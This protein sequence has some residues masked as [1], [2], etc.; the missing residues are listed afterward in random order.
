ME[1][2]VPS[3]SGDHSQTK[4]SKAADFHKKN[5]SVSS[6]RHISPR[7]KGFTNGDK[8]LCYSKAVANPLRAQDWKLQPLVFPSTT[9]QQ[10]WCKRTRSICTRW[11]CSRTMPNWT[12]VDT[13]NKFNEMKFPCFLCMRWRI[14]TEWI[15]HPLFAWLSDISCY[16][17][18]GAFPA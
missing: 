13:R 16:V 5:C 4:T 11:Y 8:G 15:R 9:A 2:K 1:E 17:A 10:P 6:I 7:G 3:D 18:K 12:G 14:Q